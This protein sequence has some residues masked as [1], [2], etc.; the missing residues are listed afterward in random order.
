MDYETLKKANRLAKVSVPV[1]LK[2]LAQ[3]EAILFDP[4][5]VSWTEHWLAKPT[6]RE[7]KDFPVCRVRLCLPDN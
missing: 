5:H 6:Q 1:M 2:R 7:E 3:E 4:A